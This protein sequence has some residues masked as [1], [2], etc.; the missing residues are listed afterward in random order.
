MPESFFG[1]P[2]L[3]SLYVNP[4]RLLELDKAGQPAHRIIA[5]R[6][7]GEEAL[8]YAEGQGKATEAYSV[9]QGHRCEIQTLETESR[10]PQRVCLKIVEMKNILAINDETHHCYR[11]KSGKTAEGKLQGKERQEAEKDREA[12]R[13]WICVLEAVERWLNAPVSLPK[14][15]QFAKTVAAQRLSRGRV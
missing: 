13:L 8:V 3:T 5:S 2:I 4:A 9:P 12:A 11:E 6:C 14:E 7:R 10:M 1:R 15:L